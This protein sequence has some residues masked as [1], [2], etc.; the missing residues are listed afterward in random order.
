[1]NHVVTG[2]ALLMIVFM[3]CAVCAGVMRVLGDIVTGFGLEEQI[4]AWLLT[5]GLSLA[6]S[7][8]FLYGTMEWINSRLNFRGARK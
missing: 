3:G 8:L 2:L 5:G 7:L 4:V 6:A 1:M